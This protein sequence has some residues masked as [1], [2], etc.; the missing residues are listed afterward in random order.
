MTTTPMQKAFIKVITANCAGVFKILWVKDGEVK[1]C[2]K[3]GYGF[4][5]TR[6]WRYF[7]WGWVA[8]KE[9]GNP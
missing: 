8:G 5:I 7:S 2:Q 9:H 1:A 4:S 6:E 3:G